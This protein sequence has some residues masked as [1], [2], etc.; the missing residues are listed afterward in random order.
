MLRTALGITVAVALTLVFAGPAACDECYGLNRWDCNQHAGCTTFQGDPGE[1]YF[2][3]HSFCECRALWRVVV[4]EHLESVEL[5]DGPY[6]YT[7]NS[8]EMAN[9]YALVYGNDCTGYSTN[10]PD[11]VA[12]V[13]LA[14]GGTVEAHMMP[15][16][17]G[18]DCSIY[19]ITDPEDPEGSCVIGADDT[20]GMDEEWFFYE[21]VEGGVYY[22]IFD[23]Y[24]SSP[25]EMEIQVWG[26]VSGSMPVGVEDA[27]WGAIKA[28]YR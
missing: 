7:Y 1:C 27:S 14:P 5:T 8:G 25:P 12:Y 13:A 17:T 28:M 2:V 11:A 21:S 15:M 26:D 9:D 4:D 19:L 10:G 22:I 18:H 6:S 24:S 23:A 3:Y 16:D 20:V